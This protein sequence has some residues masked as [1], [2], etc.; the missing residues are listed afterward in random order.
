MS[1]W[2]GNGNEITFRD[3]EPSILLSLVEMI[4][5]TRHAH[6]MFYMFYIVLVNAIVGTETLTLFA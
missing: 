3:R 6:P 2:S 4:S 5:V 1:G